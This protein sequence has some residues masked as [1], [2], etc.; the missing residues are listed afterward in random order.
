MQSFSSEQIQG[1]LQKQ[2]SQRNLDGCVPEDKC[3][4]FCDSQAAIL[5]EAGQQKGGR[6][7]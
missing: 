1:A 3:R 2:M 7:I 6:D 4:A 5:A